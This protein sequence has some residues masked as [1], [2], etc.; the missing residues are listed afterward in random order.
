MNSSSVRLYSFC[1]M[2]FNPHL[3][4]EIP[5]NLNLNGIWIENEIN[6]HRILLIYNVWSAN[7]ELMTAAAAAANNKQTKFTFGLPID[8]E[9]QWHWERARV[10][11]RGREFGRGTVY[12]MRIRVWTSYTRYSKENGIFRYPCACSHAPCWHYTH[13]ASY[14]AIP[15]VLR[16]VR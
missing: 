6:L 9:W 14:T 8:R 16:C 7:C 12:Q 11:E 2:S 10:S 4:E 15:C 5:I 1:M 13:S 3:I